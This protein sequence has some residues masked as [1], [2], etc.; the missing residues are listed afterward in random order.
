MNRSSR[1]MI[2]YGIFLVA[3]ALVAIS[4]SGW[5]RSKTAL[6]SSGSAALL[7][8]GLAFLASSADPKKM[9]IGLL[10]GPIFALIFAATFGWRLSINRGKPTEAEWLSQNPGEVV[11]T[12]LI[13]SPLQ[14]WLFP[15][16]IA[17]SLLAFVLLIVLRR[18]PTT[19]PTA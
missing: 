4:I 8:T 6:A 11:K 12:A 17:G 18:S 3:G 5:D 2:A 10:G 7:M 1:V 15:V 16:F 13:Q 14:N 19:S 9:R